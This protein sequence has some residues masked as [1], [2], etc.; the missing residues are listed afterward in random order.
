MEQVAKEEGLTP[1]EF[2]DQA[3]LI[4]VIFALLLAWTLLGKDMTTKKLLNNRKL[5]RLLALDRLNRQYLLERRA[6]RLLMKVEQDS[7][8]GRIEGRL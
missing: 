1:Q 7:A 5:K 4:F 6:I 8:L 3:I 2:T